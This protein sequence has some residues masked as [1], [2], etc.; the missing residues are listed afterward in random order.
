M[1]TE[2]RLLQA[3]NVIQDLQQ[4]QDKIYS[5][6]CDEISNRHK[7]EYSDLNIMLEDFCYNNIYY[8]SKD[9]NNFIKDLYSKEILLDNIL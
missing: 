3:R 8:S 2:D 6:L 9:I 5:E 1:L 7:A 4:R